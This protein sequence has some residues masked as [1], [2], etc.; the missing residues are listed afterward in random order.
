MFVLELGQIVDIL[1]YDNPQVVAL[2]V[3]CDILLGECFRHGCDTLAGGRKGC[4]VQKGVMM[5][6]WIR[7]RMSGGKRKR[8]VDVIPRA[9]R[10]LLAESDLHMPTPSRTC[11]GQA[12]LQPHNLLS[13]RIGGWLKGVKHP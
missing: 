7:P 10:W 6:I 3:G 5:R 1:V 8:S 11:G 9:R 12:L 13:G 2:V 4:G